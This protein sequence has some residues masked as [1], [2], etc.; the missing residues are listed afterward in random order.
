MKAST[1]CYICGSLGAT[2]GDH[3]FPRGLFAAPLP[4]DMLTAP[5]CQPCQ[6][7]LQPDEE[8]FRT[9]AAAGSYLDPTAKALWDGKIKR[10]F[11]NSRA[12]RKSFA[13][14]ISTLEW[15]SPS[16]L[17]LGQVVGLEG[18]QMRLGNVLQ[19]MVRGLSYLDSGRKVMPSDTQFNYSQ[20]SPITPPAPEFVM[21]MFHG[22]PLRTLGEVVRYKFDQS[23]DQR[24]SVSW[25]AFYSRVMFLVWT[26]PPDVVGPK[27]TRRRAPAP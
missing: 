5:A 26:G 4:S 13:N 17:Y 7:R 8:Y 23:P 22:L 27:A 14:A 16:G 25:F 9:F 24:M 3:V 11:Q 18:N 12:F 15:K 2:T 6:Q 20:E 19:K 1:A 21:T 10:S